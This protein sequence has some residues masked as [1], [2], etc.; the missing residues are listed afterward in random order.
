MD[1]EFATARIAARLARFAMGAGVALV[2]MAATPS[3]GWAQENAIRLNGGGAPYAIK[4]AAAQP[5]TFSADASFSEIVVGDPEVALV[6]PL[7]DRTFYVIGSKQGTTG[8]ALYNEA[9]QLVGTL[10]IEVGPDTRK[11]NQALA[12]NLQGS[13]YRR[14]RPTAASSFGPRQ[15][16]AGRR[17][18]ARHR[19]AI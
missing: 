12:E 11:L 19:Q 1:R 9:K 17:Q 18:G 8:V 3:F 16:P 7:T 2:L 4:I 15:E 5:R 6:T 14:N 10:D 13:R